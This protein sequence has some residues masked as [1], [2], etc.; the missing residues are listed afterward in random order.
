MISMRMTLVTL[1]TLAHRV[2]EK[3]HPKRQFDAPVLGW[4][5]HNQSFPINL[6]ARIFPTPLFQPL[7]SRPLVPTRGRAMLVHQ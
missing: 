2:F 1:V 4:V 6:P 7:N 3:R 5:L